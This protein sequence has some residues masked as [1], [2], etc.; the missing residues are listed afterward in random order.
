MSGPRALHSLR[1]EP[2]RTPLKFEE[3]VYA[4]CRGQ[5]CR[6]CV[7]VDYWSECCDMER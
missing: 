7:S 3:P 6:E 1:H 4:D 2:Q 5:L